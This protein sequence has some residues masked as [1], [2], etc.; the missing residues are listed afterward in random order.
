[1][2]EAPF[3]DTR[4]RVIRV[5][6]KVDQLEKSVENMGKKVDEMHTLLMQARGAKYVVVLVAGAAGFVASKASAIIAF[7]VK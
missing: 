1:M 4:D 2:N 3:H 7:V 5:E 6:Q